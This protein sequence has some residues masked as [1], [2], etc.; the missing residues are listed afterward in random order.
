MKKILTIVTVVFTLMTASN[1]GNVI[2]N[3]YGDFK[4]CTDTDTGE[5]WTIYEM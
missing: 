4:I 1:A 2:C 5:T 3:T